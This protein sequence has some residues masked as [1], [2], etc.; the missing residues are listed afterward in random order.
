MFYIRSNNAGD[1]AFTCN[2]SKNIFAFSSDVTDVF[3]SEDGKTDNVILSDNYYFNATSLIDSSVSGGKVYDTGGKVTD[4]GFKD[5]A[6]GD[7]TIS[8]QDINYYKIGDPR[9]HQAL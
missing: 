1:Q 4:P 5:A 3:F 8:N 7:F 2:V 6:N 9:W